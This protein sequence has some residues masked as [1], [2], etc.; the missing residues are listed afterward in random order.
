MFSNLVF[1]VYMGLSLVSSATVVKFSIHF[2]G[3]N[4]PANMEHKR[5]C[6]VNVCGSYGS[7]NSNKNLG[8]F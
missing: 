2:I 6:Y 4:I 1:S 7:I 5:K 8:V 3:R